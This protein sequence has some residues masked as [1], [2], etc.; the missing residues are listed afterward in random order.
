MTYFTSILHLTYRLLASC[1]LSTGSAW[2]NIGSLSQVGEIEEN[3][4]DVQINH[5]NEM[6]SKLHST[7]PY[8]A[9]K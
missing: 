7:Q 6:K 9:P 5:V 2:E 1:L 3:T 4:V 8:R